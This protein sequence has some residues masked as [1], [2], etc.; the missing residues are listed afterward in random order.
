[1][2]ALSQAEQKGITVY[3]IQNAM[4]DSGWDRTKLV[5]EEQLVAGRE[6]DGAHDRVYL[7]CH[8]AHYYPML[9][10]TV[11]EEIAYKPV[12]FTSA[13]AKESSSTAKPARASANSSKSGAPAS[14][15]AT[16]G[17]PSCASAAGSAPPSALANKGANTPAKHVIPNVPA[18]P[19]P[20]ACAPPRATPDSTPVAPAP[21]EH[22]PALEPVVPNPLKGV[23]GK[24][25][26]GREEHMHHQTQNLVP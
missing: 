15:I 11:E 8:N 5:V 21:A 24:M 22:A 1:V 23:C 19:T 3:T 10:L 9:E 2:W 14:S 18:K 12:K 13:K 17:G 20:S 6:L 26:Y 16:L 4:L 7:F 25:V